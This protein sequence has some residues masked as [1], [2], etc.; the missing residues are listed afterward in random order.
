MVKIISNFHEHCIGRAPTWFKIIIQ[1]KQFQESS[2]SSKE[3]VSATSYP[4][5]HPNLLP[6]DDVTREYFLKSIKLF[7]IIF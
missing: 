3:Q 1:I 5:F 2:D 6:E 7:L 4:K